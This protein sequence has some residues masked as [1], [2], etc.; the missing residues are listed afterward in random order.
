MNHRERFSLTMQH[1]PVDRPPLD[2]GGT[3]L[4]GMR[5][6]CQAQL[7]SFLGFTGKPETNQYGMDERILTWADTGFRSVGDII[8]LPSPLKRTLSDTARIDCWGVRR[9]YIEGEWQITASPL[10]NASLEDLQHFPWPQV[11][12]DSRLLD[13]WQAQAREL[14]REGHYVVAALHPVYGILELGCWMCG[15]SEFL[16]KMAMEPDFVRSFFDRIVHIQMG[17]IDQYY[18]ALG[19]YIDLTTSG[20]DFGTQGGPFMSPRMF[21][22]LIAPYFSTRIQR[23]KEL[24]HCYFWHH[25]CGSV[26]ELLDQ[27][28]TCGVDILNPVQTSAARMEPAKLKQVYGD[29][30]VFWGGVDVQQFLPRADP[31]QVKEEVSR[32]AR[33]LGKDG[34]Y[35][36]APAHEMLAD[37]PS[38]NI[39]AWVTTIIRSI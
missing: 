16:L 19:G 10:R 36:M 21:Q 29:Q 24:A 2:I 39:N 26:F 18:S 32:L 13:Q 3:P 28:I 5:P 17:V 33:V 38:E 35:V 31:E 30:I 7:R 20:D 9:D 37:I 14:Q 23:T 15:Y 22:R 11:I 1:K 34:G 27:L 8:E 25:S 6:E 4:T 12:I